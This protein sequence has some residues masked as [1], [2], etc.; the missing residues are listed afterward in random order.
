MSLRGIKFSMLRPLFTHHVLYERAYEILGQVGMVEKKNEIV[1]N[2]SHGEQRQIEIS[3]ALISDP[4]VLLLDEPTA[5]LS[6]AESALMARTVQ[7]L[8][9]QITILIIEHDMDVAFQIAER[10]SVLHQGCL[11]AEGT[12]DEIR[13]ND[14]VQEIYFGTEDNAC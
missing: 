3:L 9:P 8:D 6:S 13:S 12:V 1:S 4:K 2:L 10:I 7:S 5:G 11:F 14:R